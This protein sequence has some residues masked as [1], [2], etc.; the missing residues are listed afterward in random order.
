MIKPATDAHTT[1]GTK[2]Q[3]ASYMNYWGS[4]CAAYGLSAATIGKMT[5]QEFVEPEL[6]KQKVWAEVQLLAGFADYFVLFPQRKAQVHNSTAHAERA[7]GAVRGHYQSINDI[8]PGKD[9]LVDCGNIIKRVLKGL[10]KLYPTSNQKML[11]LLSTHMKAIKKVMNIQ[12]L[13]DATLW[14]LWLTQ[15]QGLMRG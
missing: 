8:I 4:Y 3:K 14:A 1:P 15:W 7:I 12:E 2:K 9:Q 5:T 10:G 6:R 13:E 11:S